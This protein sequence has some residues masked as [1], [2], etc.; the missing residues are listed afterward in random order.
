MKPNLCEPAFDAA[1]L[2]DRAPLSWVEFFAGQAEATRMFRYAAF[3]TGRL[4]LTYMQA[5]DKFHQNPMDL[6]SDAGFA[7]L[8]GNKHVSTRLT[9]DTKETHNICKQMHDHVSRLEGIHWLNYRIC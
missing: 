1:I 5:K 3:K 9:I 2:Q 8:A 4:D 7:W 6:T